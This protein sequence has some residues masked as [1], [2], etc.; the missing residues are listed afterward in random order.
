MCVR[1]WALSVGLAL[2]L[3]ASP[4]AWAGMACFCEPQMECEDHCCQTAHHPEAVAEMQ[5][6]SST[7]ETSTWCETATE[8][9]GVAQASFQSPPVPVCCVMQPLSEPP[10]RYFSPQ[11]QVHAA[12]AQPPDDLRW[13]LKPVFAHTFNPIC[14]C[15]KRPLYLTFSRLLI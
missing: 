4:Q 5:S 11:P 15:S 12:I 8:A 3:T 10:A 6:G 2:A 1:Q 14:W 9:R 7:R 13:F